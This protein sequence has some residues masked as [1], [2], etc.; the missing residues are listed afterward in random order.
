MQV[1]QKTVVIE[2][3]E[4]VAETVISVLLVVRKVSDSAQNWETHQHKDHTVL[5][6]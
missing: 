4:G 2:D 3:R 1:G 5:G 6:R